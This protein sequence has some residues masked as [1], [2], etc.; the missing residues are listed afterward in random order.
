MATKTVKEL[1]KEKSERVMDGVAYWGAFYRENPQRFVK[2][3][4]NIQLK[5]FQKI[6]IYLMMHSTNFLVI[7]SRG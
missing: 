1:T 4:L 3:Y 6:L 7:A 5:L 2:D